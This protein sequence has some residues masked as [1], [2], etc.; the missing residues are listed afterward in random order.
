[1]R[2][3]TRGGLAATLN[4][5]AMQT[6]LVSELNEADIPVNPSVQAA[7]DALGLDVLNIANEGKFVAVVA[8]RYR[9][10]LH[11]YLPSPSAGKTGGN[12]RRGRRN[13][14]CPRRRNDY[15]NWRQKNCPDALRKR[16]AEDLLMHEATIAQSVLEAISAEAKKQKAKPIAAKISCGVFKRYKQ[17]GPLFRLRGHQQRYRLRRSKT[18]YR[19]KADTGQMQKMR[20]DLRSLTCTNQNARSAGMMIL[21]CCPMRRFCLKK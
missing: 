5:I 18:Q 9:R 12:N 15:K 14:R 21:S 17:R 4:E 16:T 7:A 2:D 6:R 10:R 19:A 20:C 13:R 1:M 3:P 8:P 11:Q